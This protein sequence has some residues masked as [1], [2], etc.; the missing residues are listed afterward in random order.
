MT[1]ISACLAI[2]QL[3]AEHAAELPL[4]EIAQRLNLPKSGTHRLLATLTDLG[5]ATQDPQ[6]GFY[7]LTL[8]LT[9]LGQRFYAATGIPDIC[10]PVIDRLATV[11]REFVRMAVVDSN[12]LVWVTF[13]QGA[14]GG[15]IY[16]PSDTV[17]DVPLHAT[18]TGKAW[19]STL[20]TEEAME[21]VAKQGVI[22][23][24]SSYG[25]NVVRS[26]ESL[27]EELRTTAERGYGLAMSEAEPGV[28]ALAAA[29]RLGRGGTAVGTVSVAGPSIRLN[30]KRVQEL[31]PIVTAA[32]AEL[33]K[34]WPLRLRPDSRMQPTEESVAGALST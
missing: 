1:H 30:E 3:L 18:A 20:P 28:T 13:A 25:P 14:K 24:P 5:W 34:L 17:A 7:K 29:I 4:G 32:A 26:L 21:I 33:A 27:Q 23:G 9:V 22:G 31:A 16:Q 15:L 11:S 12:V 8:K 10:Q 19:L 2:I 6:T